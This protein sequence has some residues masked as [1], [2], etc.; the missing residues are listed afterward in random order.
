MD[1]IINNGG[2]PLMPQVGDAEYIIEYWRSVGVAMSTGM[3]SAPISATEL[4]NWAHG[5]GIEL[6]PFEFTAVLEMS[7]SYLGSMQQG[8]QPN[9]PP[10]YGD[11]VNEFDRQKVA[12]KISNAFKAF[13][14]AK[15]KA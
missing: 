15:R 10:P 14:G 2:S 12:S 8:E 7:R 11:P 5:Q 1:S 4:S 13:I 9:C 3:G 6:A